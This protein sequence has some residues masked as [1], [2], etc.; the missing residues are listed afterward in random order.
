MVL[1]PLLIISCEA[2]KMKA[3][4]RSTPLLSSNSKLCGNEL[5]TRKIENVEMENVSDMDR[6]NTL[7]V[8]HW[9]GTILKIYFFPSVARAPIH[10]TS[11]QRC[12]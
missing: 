12:L 1:Y 11:Y 6:A 8:G 3:E 7:K 4:C 2:C 9:A 10:R 5:F